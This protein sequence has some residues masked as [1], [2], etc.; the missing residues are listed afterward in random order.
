MK[1][2][3][4]WFCGSAVVAGALCGLSGCGGGGGGGGGIGAAS[5]LGVAPAPVAAPV[6]IE[7]TGPNA[8]TRWSEVAID[9][10]NLPASATGTA[11]EQRPVDSVDL[12]TVHLA[13]YNALSQ[14]TGRYQPYGES[15][16][17]TPQDASQEAAIA[18]AARDV[19]LALYP[20]R[21]TSYA[22]AFDSAV[23]AIPE[24]ASKSSGLAIGAEA[25]RRILVVRANDGRSVVLAPYVPGTTPGRFRGINPVNRFFSSIRPFSLERAAQFRTPEPPA[26]QSDVYAADLNETRARGGATSSVRTAAQLEAARFHTEPPPRFWPRNLRR[27]AM[28]SGELVDQAR[29]LAMLFTVQADA[30][31]ACFESKYAY[32]YWRP[33]SAIP[34]ADQ[35]G[36][37]A[38]DP[39]PTWVPVLA[40][41]NHPE[42]PAAHACTASAVA[43]T[44]RAYFGTAQIEFS[45][46]SAVTGSTH[47]FTSLGGFVEEIRGARIDGGMHFRNSLIRGE[48]QGAAVARWVLARNFQAR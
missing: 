27:L 12:A 2:V 11:A 16:A 41:P 29:L 30:T 1:S 42:Y 20:S 23:T 8:V 26:L 35:D 17:S 15:V 44:M 31:I 7:T 19:L 18:Q 21:A 32:D 39:D 28:T 6:R 9:T 36:N 22:A 14:I 33:L 43:E 47:R 5:G 38:T 10:I 46:D 13:I 4:F 37:A 24:G 3:F 34:L 25:A 45:F 48:E 40:T